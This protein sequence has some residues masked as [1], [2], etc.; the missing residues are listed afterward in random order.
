MRSF[1]CLLLGLLLW[2]PP[3]AHARK[4]CRV[5]DGEERC[6]VS[7][8]RNECRVLQKQI[9]RYEGD[10][11]RARERDNEL[12]EN[13]TVQHIQRLEARR[14]RRCPEPEGDGTLE[15]VAELIGK[16]ARVAAKAFTSGLF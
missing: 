12:W 3:D 16:A 6:K 2:M 4:E 5:I 7:D 1:A 11:E 10:V 9:T 8:G 14:Q 15:V 13:V